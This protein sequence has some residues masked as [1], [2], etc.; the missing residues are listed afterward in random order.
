D[1][2]RELI[3]RRFSWSS[4]GRQYCDFIS[5]VCAPSRLAGGL[6]RRVPL[7]RFESG[8]NG[9]GSQASRLNE[10]PAPASNSTIGIVAIGR[11]EGDRLRQCL[12]SLAGL[13]VVYVDSG[14]TD[15]SV[16]L[17]KSRGVEVVELDMGTP[18]TA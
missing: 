13:S 3:R 12:D 8:A 1:A 2:R 5:Q 15:A 11:N 18:F 6:A 10:N 14:S 7:D 17:A 9:R 16:A 4:I